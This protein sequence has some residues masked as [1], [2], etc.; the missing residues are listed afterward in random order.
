MR[1]ASAFTSIASRPL[2]A[3]LTPST[4]PLFIRHTPRLSFPLRVT[5]FSTMSSAEDEDRQAAAEAG[6]T[7]EQQ[8]AL[9]AYHSEQNFLLLH[10][11]QLESMQLPKH[12]W[13]ALYHKIYNETFDAGSTFVIAQHEDERDGEEDEEDEEEEDE[14]VGFHLVVAAEGGVKAGEEVWILEHAFS[15]PDKEAVQQ[16]NAQ[17]ALVDRLWDMLD[18]DKRVRREELAEDRRKKRERE[19]QQR[20][21]DRKESEDAV[22]ERRLK[23]AEEEK[24]RERER[25]LAQEQWT[26]DES[27]A[28]VMSQAQATREQ[29]T[30]ALIHSRGDLI[31]AINAVNTNKSTDAAPSSSSTSS[32]SIPTSSSTP[33]TA[34]TPS[35]ASASSIDLFSLT[36]PE[37]RAKRVYDALFTYKYAS[38]QHTL[39]S[40]LTSSDKQALTRCV[41]CA[42]LCC[43][44]IGCYYTTKPRD[45]RRA[46]TAA[47]VTAHLYVNEEAGSAVVEAHNPTAQLCSFMCVTLNTGLSVLWLTRD[48]D[49]G[50]E[51]IR[52]V[53]PTVRKTHEW[54]RG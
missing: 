52:P 45:E 12:L 39:P 5:L 2:F 4:T 29:A 26:N 38:T 34:A 49:Q 33:S 27:V 20:R 51:V 44:Y 40:I 8:A 21:E 28:C 47:D 50:E 17:P 37:R 3:Q 53:R 25:Q 1:C 18:M 54:T 23:E 30:Q 42:A 13:S 6:L 24:E 43:R 10:R 41:V 11:P 36:E 19:E 46:L 32:S 9:T 22:E 15:A 31:D 7:E 48:L 14:D 16:L 35:I